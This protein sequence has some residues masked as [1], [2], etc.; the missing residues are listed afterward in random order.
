MLQKNAVDRDIIIID[1]KT[2][3]T[4]LYENQHVEL[5]VFARKEIMPGPMVS[6]SY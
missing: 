1:T 3:G 5:H 6:P 4:G 2:K